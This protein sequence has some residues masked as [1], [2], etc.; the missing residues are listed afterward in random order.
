MKFNIDLEVKLN[1]LYLNRKIRIV[2][3]YSNFILI[4]I[5]KSI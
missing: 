2:I 5:P 3:F 1:L 4:F